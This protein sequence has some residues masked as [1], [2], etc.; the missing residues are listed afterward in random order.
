MAPA[1]FATASDWLDAIWWSLEVAADRLLRASAAAPPWDLLA[2]A[3]AGATP[4][5][6]SIFCSARSVDLKAT[7]VRATAGSLFHS[8]ME[9]WKQ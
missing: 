3:L 2:Y 5:S 8:C 1:S 4:L 7:H 6:R 9:R